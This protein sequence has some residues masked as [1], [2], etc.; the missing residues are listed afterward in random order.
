[1]RSRFLVISGEGEVGVTRNSGY[2]IMGGC[3]GMAL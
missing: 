3:E 1:M 2:V